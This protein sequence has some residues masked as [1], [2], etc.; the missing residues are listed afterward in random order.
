MRYCAGTTPFAAWRRPPRPCGLGM[1]PTA[2][3]FAIG[4]AAGR[5]SMAPVVAGAAGAAGVIWS[6]VKPP[7]RLMTGAFGSK[8]PGAATAA[9]SSGFDAG[10]TA[11]DRCGAGLEIA[12]VVFGSSI[13]GAGSASWLGAASTGSIA[14]AGAGAGRQHDRGEA[15]EKR[16]AMLG[17]GAF[18]ARRKT[19]IRAL[20]PRR[21]RSFP[22]PAAAL[23]LGVGSSLGG[24]GVGGAPRRRDEARLDVE[25]GVGVGAGRAWTRARGARLEQD[26]LEARRQD[27]L[28][29]FAQNH[30][31]RLAGARRRGGSAVAGRRR[32]NLDPRRRRPL[33]RGAG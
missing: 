16:P 4:V 21:Q 23:D 12:C 31:R 20:H 24:R 30:R 25:V 11:S 17:H 10:A 5:G 2:A 26:L 1:S 7:G 13:F 9:R 3:T 27:R 15:E 18:H 8:R 14:A 19:V 22:G 28:I 32:L 33:G 29:G 6:G